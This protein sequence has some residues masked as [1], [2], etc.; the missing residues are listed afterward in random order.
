MF[1]EFTAVRIKRP[2]ERGHR[3]E[4]KL[5]VSA[6][7]QEDEQRGRG[8]RCT[9]R[10]YDRHVGAAVAGQVAAD[11]RENAP[12]VV[13]ARAR[14]RDLLHPVCERCCV[15]GDPRVMMTAVRRARC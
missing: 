11:E 10:E 1:D 13:I 4:A 7:R 9:A 14:Q 5:P 2:D 3:A 6:V 12:P 15:G 8:A